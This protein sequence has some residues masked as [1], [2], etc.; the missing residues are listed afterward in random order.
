MAYHCLQTAS[1]HRGDGRVDR[2]RFI[3]AVASGLV[4]VRPIAGAQP[5][6]K[7]YRVGFL[8]GASRESVESLFG[9]FHDGMRDLGYVDGRNVV[10]EQRYA[11]G[12]MERLPNLATELVRLRP[13]AIVT[14]SS[15]HVAAVKHATSTIPVVMVF[16]AD[17]VGAGF[18]E[19]LAHPG[20]NIT[21]LSADASPE[22]WAKYLTLLKE[23]VPKLTRV[24]VMGQVSAQV[25]FTQIATAA[26]KL[27]IALEVADLRQPS[28]FDE[29]FVGL[30]HR[31]AEALVVVVSPLTYLLKER[32][33]EAAL[34]NR[35]P[36]ISNANQYAQA[37]LL[38]SYGPPLLDL[39]R[40]AAT[41]VDKILRGTPPADLPVE[42]PSKFELVINLK[43]SKALNL[44]I[45]PSLLARADE[46]IR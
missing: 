5:A 26:R 22:L 37:G 39:Y 1:R 25:E 44:A 21:G 43:T 27:D 32:I 2:R 41:Y 33:A 4:V 29:Q 30:M 19:S 35:L 17:P 28:D 38:M 16:T 42:Q 7:V 13:D 36:T 34:K 14:G 9:A 3:A 20:G 15:I 23:V 18:V 40:Q 12:K 10:Y 11:A 46:I 31:K 8:L 6:A 24:G 45:P